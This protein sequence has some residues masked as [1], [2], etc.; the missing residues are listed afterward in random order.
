MERLSDSALEKCL[1][2]SMVGF[3][4]FLLAAMYLSTL[5]G[6]IA[7]LFA[8]PAGLFFWAQFFFT[9]ERST[10]NRIKIATQRLSEKTS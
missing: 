8:F 10:R 2:G 5:L 9:I 4:I 7:V 1:M 3:I 6:S